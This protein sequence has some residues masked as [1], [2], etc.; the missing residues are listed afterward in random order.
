MV[1]RKSFFAWEVNHYYPI[2]LP[3]HLTQ[4]IFL[5]LSN[6]LGTS[7]HTHKFEMDEVVCCSTW[8]R[9]ILLHNIYSKRKH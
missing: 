9:N 1:L 8:K 2:V 4:S 7:D 3:Y 6:I 5:I